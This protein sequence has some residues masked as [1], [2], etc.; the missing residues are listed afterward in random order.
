MLELALLQARGAWVGAA[1]GAAVMAPLPWMGPLRLEGRAR[2]RLGL[3]AA[4]AGAGVVLVLAAVLVVPAWRGAALARAGAALRLEAVS[5]SRLEGLRC[6]PPLLRGHLLLGTGPEGIRG[7]L[8]PWKDD[9][10]ARSLGLQQVRDFH[11]LPVQALAEG[12]LAGLA[13]FLGLLVVA[14]RSLLGTIR[15]ARLDAR[16]RWPAA[17]LLAGLA[18]HLANGLTIGHV[19]GSEVIWQVAL[20]LAAGAAAS[21]GR[22]PAG[23]AAP[24]RRPAPRI[25]RAAAAT[26]LLAL[27]A[28][29]TVYAARL[30]RADAA[31]L[32][33]LRS[34]R[35]LETGGGEA[36]LRA[37]LREGRRAVELSPATAGY[38][39]QLASAIG[40]GIQAA[41]L[42]GSPLRAE[43][44]EVG[45]REAREA[46]RLGEEQENAALE[47][48]RLLEL[49]GRTD[50]AIEAARASIAAD[51]HLWQSHRILALLLVERGRLGEARKELEAVERLHPGSR[52]GDEVDRLR[53]AIGEAEARRGK[54]AGG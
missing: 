36:D 52:A 38:H 17:G 6:A 40:K 4:A 26:V 9:V 28:V 33:C 31:L 20:G 24:A 30:W 42:A 15:D 44:L 11:C 35:R 2:R 34:G 14:A 48:A 51:G 3:A 29:S 39:L 18:A 10:L 47:E 49:S 7:A 25:A 54:G 12:G 23:A 16:A 53:R 37:T 8:L 45:L 43:A 50:L 1:V 41:E 22:S 13:A 19:V 5:N 32:R 46:F 27:L 21:P